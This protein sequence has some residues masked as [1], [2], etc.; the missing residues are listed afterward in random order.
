VILAESVFQNP[1]RI[2]ARKPLILWTCGTHISSF[3]IQVILAGQPE[4]KCFSP[5]TFSIF[6][7]SL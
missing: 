7:A 2:G 4:E 1:F 3:Q 6:S 5:L